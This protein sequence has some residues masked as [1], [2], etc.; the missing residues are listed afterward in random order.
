ME[1]EQKTINIDFILNRCYRTDAKTLMFS[2]AL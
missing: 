2:H 1:L